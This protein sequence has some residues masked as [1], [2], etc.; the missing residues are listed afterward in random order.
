MLHTIEKNSAALNFLEQYAIDQCASKS[1]SDLKWVL[2]KLR[3][4]PGPTSGQVFRLIV[5]IL[6][7]RIGHKATMVHLC[8]TL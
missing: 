6:K 3:L 8:K 2:S 7:D 1:T 4:N 5:A